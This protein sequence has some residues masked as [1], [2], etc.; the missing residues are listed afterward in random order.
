MD[1]QLDDGNSDTGKVRAGATNVVATAAAVSGAYGPAVAA[2]AVL[3]AGL[4]T[5]C[6]KL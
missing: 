5:I 6:M 3:E 1:A 2:T 4:H